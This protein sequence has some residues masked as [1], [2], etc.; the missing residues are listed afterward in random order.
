MR[1]H[2]FRCLTI[3]GIYS[4]ASAVHMGKFMRSINV[5]QV[6]AVTELFV[7]CS[8]SDHPDSWLPTIPSTFIGLYTVVVI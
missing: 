5:A 4:D 3:N 1:V 2:M 6:A 8:V 7:N